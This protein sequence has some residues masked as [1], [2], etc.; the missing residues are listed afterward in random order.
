M[1][2]TACVLVKCPMTLFGC[3]VG[4]AEDNLHLPQES[5]ESNIRC[6]DTDTHDVQT[7]LLSAKIG[8]SAG[9]T[10]N[11]SVGIKPTIHILPTSHD[12]ALACGRKKR[13]HQMQLTFY[14]P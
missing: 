4:K 8:F 9:R 13:K 5:L 11:M 2:V 3:R 7:T 1:M 6:C 12:A 14:V 10:R